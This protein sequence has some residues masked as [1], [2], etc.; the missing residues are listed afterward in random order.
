MTPRERIL[1]I[2]AQLP[3]YNR[4]AV[5]G[6]PLTGKSLISDTI[7]DRLHIATDFYRYMP[8]DEQASAI[9][10]ALKGLDRFLLTGVRT[11]GVLMHGLQV[12][13]VVWL[14]VPL[15]PLTKEQETMRR[16]ARTMFS[17]WA[18][19]DVGRP[20]IMSNVPGSIHGIL[21]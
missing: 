1:E 4:I 18:A 13:C 11:A 3:A 2:A 17:R 9:S 8:W 7:T 10:L 14:D 19:L 5:A 12:D 21:R 15:Q 20:R 6:G 16:G